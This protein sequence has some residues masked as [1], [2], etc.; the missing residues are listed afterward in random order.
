MG[1]LR[2]RGALKSA[3]DYIILGAGSA[4]CA[5]ASHLTRSLPPSSSVLVVEAGP[6]DD[7]V[8]VQTPILAGAI[9]PGDF[10]KANRFNWSLESEQDPGIASR[11]SFF[12]RGCGL[13]GSSSINAMLYVRG[14]PEDYNDWRDHTGS[15]AWGY[16]SVLPIFKEMEGNQ[17]GENKDHGAKGPLSV[18]WPS[19]ESVSLPVNQAFLEACKQYGMVY[20]ED[21]NRSEGTEGYGIYQ[22]TVTPDGKRCSAA[23]AFLHPAL[24]KHDNLSVLTE[25]SAVKLLF[26]EKKRVSG[27]RFTERSGSGKLSTAYFDVQVKEEVI[28]SQGAFH[29]PQLLQ[30]SGIGAPSALEE[31]GIEVVCANSNVGENLQ[32][33]LDVILVTK[34]GAY[35]PTKSLSL[36][37]L[38][39][40]ASET[41]RYSKTGKGIG[42]SILETGAFLRSLP[43]LT[44]PDLQLHFL[45]TPLVDHARKKIFFDGVSLHACNLYPKSKGSVS[46]RSSNP[47]DS[48]VIRPNFLKEKEDEETILR[49]FDIVAKLLISPAFDS[50]NHKVCF[51]SDSPLSLS[52]EEKLEF[53]RKNSDGIYH[54]VGTCRMGKSSDPTSV[55][56]PSLRLLGVEGV[57]VADASIMPNLIGG[58]TNAPSMMIGAQCAKFILQ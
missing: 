44:R 24:Q 1:L 46:L 53:I 17:M 30:L 41:R 10:P 27:V 56:D 45:A 52:R 33:H 11:K 21:F 7:S 57:R 23:R 55:V 9:V 20:T 2:G 4:G 40:L 31:K 28:V 51:L 36:S 49:A 19:Q 22:S 14:H 38:S 26:D 32:E 34:L 13:G 29:S 50:F 3:Y 37:N 6:S 58:N 5:A 43:S 15:A 35:S 8:F 47:Q 16:S 48:P 39:F 18:V 12:P 54:P 42:T 25:T